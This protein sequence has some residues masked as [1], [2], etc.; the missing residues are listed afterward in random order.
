MCHQTEMQLT[1]HL[2]P[3]EEGGF[4]ARLKEFPGVIS[5][6]D[7][8]EEALANLMDALATYLAWKSTQELA[9]GRARPVGENALELSIA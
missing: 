8:Q 3:A 6:G 9:A 5:E 1:A 2:E 7:D 4:T